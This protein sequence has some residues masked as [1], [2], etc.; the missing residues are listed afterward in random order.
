MTSSDVV[1]QTLVGGVTQL[2]AS[3]RTGEKGQVQN[4]C[5]SSAVEGLRRRPHSEH[6]G[7]LFGLPSLAAGSPTFHL[8]DRGDERYVVAI[9]DQS[10]SGDSTLGVFDILTGASPVTVRDKNGDPATTADFGYLDC[11]DPT[12]DIRTRTLGDITWVVNRTKKVE[13]VPTLTPAWTPSALFVVVKGGYSTT[14][15]LTVN[16]RT[17]TFR[18]NSAVIAGNE[19]FVTPAYIVGKMAAGLTGTPSYSNSTNP[20]TGAQDAI[21]TPSGA[22][23][24]PAEWIIETYSGV[25][26]IERVDGA[27]FTASIKD[28]FTTRSTLIKGKATAFSELPTVAPDGINV[29]IDGD[30]DLEG[31]EYYLTFISDVPGAF[32]EGDWTQTVAPGVTTT[33]DP[34]TMPHILV[35]LENGEFLFAAADG[36]AYNHLGVEYQIPEWASRDVG[37]ENSNPIPSFVGKEIRDILFFGNR[38]VVVSGQSVAMS[39]LNDAFQFWRLTVRELLDTTRIDLTMPHDRVVLLH[40]AAVIGGQLYPLGEK[41]QFRTQ[42]DNVLSPS[43]VSA[44]AMGEYSTDPNVRPI[45]MG[46][47]VFVADKRGGF[48]VIREFVDS[49]AQRPELLDQGVMDDLPAFITGQVRAI[50][51]SDSLNTLVVTSIGEPN[52][53]YVLNLIV[54]GGKRALNSWSRQTSSGEVVLA[55]F[56]GTDLYLL[57]KRGLVYS[58]EV[59][60][61]EPFA[62]DAG[63]EYAVALDR[64]FTVTPTVMDGIR[65]VVDVPYATAG[66][67]A[68]FTPGGEVPDVSDIESGSFKILGDYTGQELICGERF[69]SEYEP[70]RAFVRTQSQSG[71]SKNVHARGLA[72]AGAVVEV[73]DTGFLAVTTEDN[74]SSYVDFV[75]PQTIGGPASG[76]APLVSGQQVFDVLADAEGYAIMF[77]SDSHLPFRLISLR[78]TLRWRQGRRIL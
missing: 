55:D 16:S 6:V 40:S 76:T 29:K 31:G 27:D 22:A 14:Y 36:T 62:T 52:V 15:E 32:G 2:A 70:S 50:S 53:Y 19:E 21:L 77:S 74:G 59:A 18:T 61:M 48:S 9:G 33:I 64:R 45:S 24:D 60:D 25:A 28:S 11:E 37:G 67:M 49:Q 35:R 4:N 12:R 30:E 78:L 69:L 7:D 38:L 73:E 1:Y 44:K 10:E 46:R 47:S 57:V 17:V 23:L 51:A 26:R 68:A 13:M 66:T 8:I 58:L 34:T 65:T 63:R 5:I 39:T 72:V 75:S 3:L 54:I 42:G 41:T 43:T 56:I 71:G 20:S